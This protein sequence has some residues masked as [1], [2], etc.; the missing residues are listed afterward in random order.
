MANESAKF[1]KNAFIGWTNTTGMYYPPDF[2]PNKLVSEKKYNR[3]KFAGTKRQKMPRMMNIRMM[4]PFSMICTTCGNFSYVATKF[5]SQV[6]KIQNE[7]YF[8]C[9]IYRFYGKCQHCLAVFTFK[10]DPASADYVMETGGKRSYECWKDADGAVEMVAKTKEEE[11]AGDALKALE[12]ASEAAQAE[13]KINDAIEGQQQINN[14]LKYP[15]ESITQALEFIYREKAKEE[16][17]GDTPLDDDF[18]DELEEYRV[19]QERKKK[20]ELDD[21][22]EKND[23]E[24]VASS[25]SS[26][27]KRLKLEPDDSTVAASASTSSSLASKQVEQELPKSVVVKK[28]APPPSAIFRVKLKPETKLEG[29]TIGRSAIDATT[30]SGT[31]EDS[32]STAAD[33]EVLNTGQKKEEVKK[34]PSAAPQSAAFGGFG[35]Y[36]SESSE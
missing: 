13:M 30:P 28:K 12:Q 27:V 9:A 33:G 36:D 34:E 8:G 20:R 14:R 26:A 29:I 2:D 5:N 7:S 23:D 16:R 11:A 22:I 35:A 17:E 6:E 15:Y 25:S 32:V 24:A 18:E 19:E 21:E 31:T 10:T 3:E 4:M 1:M